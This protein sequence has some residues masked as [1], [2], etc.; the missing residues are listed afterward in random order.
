MWGPPQSRSVRFYED[1]NG[2]ATRISQKNEAKRALKKSKEKEKV[3]LD[4]RPPGR[5]T[6]TKIDWERPV[7]SEEEEAD[8]DKDTAS[9]FNVIQ[10][11]SDPIYSPEEDEL[12]TLARVVSFAAAMSEQGFFNLLDSLK[13]NKWYDNYCLYEEVLADQDYVE[14]ETTEED[15][16][17]DVVPPRMGRAVQNPIEDTSSEE[18]LVKPPTVTRELKRSC[19]ASLGPR[20]RKV[21]EVSGSVSNR[22]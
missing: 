21:V 14:G 11:N 6:Q 8:H 18:D 19:A 1:K 17:E 22:R 2:K 3:R 15:L 9:R 5:L 12:Q 13:T 7:L 16:P 10:D 20:K 4:S